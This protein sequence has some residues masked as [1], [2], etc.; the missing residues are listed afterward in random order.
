MK[1]YA[2]AAAVIAGSAAFAP[3]AEAATPGQVIAGTG[4]ELI[5][6][7]Q[8]TSLAPGTYTVEFDSEAA[9][10]RLTPYLK[11][12]AANTSA[13]TAG[14]R[15]VVSTT[16]QR[17]VETGC[18]KAGTLVASLEYRPISKS[19]YSWGGNCFNLGDHSLHSGIL[20][21]DTEWWYPGWFS[22]TPTV[23]EYKIRN[24]VTH[25]FGHAI[26]LDHPN[27]DLNHDGIVKSYECPKNYNGALPVMCAPLGGRHTATSAGNYTPLDIPG[28]RALVSN[29]AMAGA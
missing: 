24:A 28:L 4:W 20:R 6:A 13:Q 1:L 29:Y 5:S 2:L 26:G 16:I 9:R 17:R 12:S 14:V 22:A 7:D 27:K 18:Q 15:F 23:N 21:F 3:T 10:E 11:L 8:T 25:E 19:G